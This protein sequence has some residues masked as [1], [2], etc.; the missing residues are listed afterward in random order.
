LKLEAFPGCCGGAIFTGFYGTTNQLNDRYEDPVTPS[1]DIRAPEGL[2]EWVADVRS[3]IDKTI[4][5]G[6]ERDIANVHNRP[7]GPKTIGFYQAVLNKAQVAIFHDT[8][9]DLGF[10][11]VAKDVLNV[12]YGSKMT[13][14][15]RVTHG[16]NNA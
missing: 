7:F 16:E 2:A 12:R 15:I 9:I 5:N 8:L 11:V 4:R 13:V 14:Y 1:R 6:M 3:Y 10:R